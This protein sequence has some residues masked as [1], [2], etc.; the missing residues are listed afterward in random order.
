VGKRQAARLGGRNLVDRLV[1]ALASDDAF[2]AALLLACGLLACL[3]HMAV[4][5]IFGEA[6]GA[7]ELAA[8]EREL[9]AT[10]R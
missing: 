3:A 2:V 5:A 8:A 10:S 9:L 4:A 6:Q 1:R 7:S